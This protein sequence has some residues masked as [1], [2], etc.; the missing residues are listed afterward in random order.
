M[1]PEGRSAM[2][3]PSALAPDEI[4]RQKRVCRRSS[5]L[6][7]LLFAATISLPLAANL[8]GV[9]GADPG[10]ENRELAPF[11]HSDG[12]LASTAAFPAGFSAW[13]EDHFG[14][15][16]R[17]VRWFGETRLFVL[18]TSPS[19][20]VVRGEDGWFFYGDDKSVEDYANVE[21][22]TDAALANWRAAILRAREWLR[23]RHIAYIFTITPDKYVIYGE[24]MPATLERVGE[25]SRADQLFT[26][27]QDTGLAVD[28]RAVEF[29]A[30]ARE[31]VYQRTDTHWNDRGALVAYQQ[32]IGA[33]R[34]RVPQTPP[35]WRRE[36]FTAADRT[37]D[38][39]DLAGMMGL[40]R[41]LG[42]VDLTLV[43]RRARRAHVVEPA[44]AR[45]TDEEGRLV[46][47]IDD[48][49]LP[50]AVI[51][52][53]SFTSRL[54]PFLSEHFSRAVY[55]WQNDFDATVV[56]QEHPDVVI[57]QMVGRHLYNFIPSPELVPNP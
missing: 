23:A 38:G 9:D 56:T 42:E 13:F 17:L 48:P 32:I 18:R 40:T 43:P 39:P 26:A 21:P 36:D 57:Q 7:T 37:I 46:T 24:K 52:R 53:D 35:P 20:T 28:V 34:A 4:D 55:L 14:F 6:L 29:D 8:I 5:A 31:R 51:F 15:R 49:S 1:T 3:E 33:V 47:E 19:A 2:H 25:L 12:S 54:V 22:M 10:A 11:P 45:P 50:R 16:S 41:V 44:G 30:K 27:L